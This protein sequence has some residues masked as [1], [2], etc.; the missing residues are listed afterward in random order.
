MPASIS[1]VDETILGQVLTA[2]QGMNPARQAARAAGLPDTAPAATISQVCGSGLRAV[3]L[4]LQQI[5]TGSAAIVV[6]GGQESM[7]NAPHVAAI[8]QGRKLGNLELVDTVATACSA[9]NYYPMGNTA[10]VA[11]ARGRPLGAGHAPL[12]RSKKPQ[13]PPIPAASGRDRPGRLPRER[14]TRGRHRRASATTRPR[15][16]GQASRIR[17]RRPVTAITQ[18]SITAR[19]TGADDGG[20]GERAGSR[21]QHR[22]LGHAGVDPQVGPPPSASHKALDRAGWRPTTSTSGRSAGPSAKLAVI[23]ELGLDPPRQRQQQRQ[24]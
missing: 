7:S 20:R 22:R 13:P 24:R 17:R 9:F 18:A 4:G 11:R 23:G 15:S 5:Q 14:A 12:P 8:R 2:G 6:A 1:D 19:G 21:P 10:R 16:H 3:A